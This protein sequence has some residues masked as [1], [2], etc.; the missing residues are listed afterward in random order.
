MRR[1]RP[2]GAR[3][4][5]IVLAAIG[6][7]LGLYLSA[8]GD[9]RIL[10]WYVAAASAAVLVMATLGLLED[11]WMAG[12]TAIVGIGGTALVIYWCIDVN[13]VLFRDALAPFAW[14]CLSVAVAVVALPVTALVERIRHGSAR[15]CRRSFAAT[16]LTLTFVFFAWAGADS[17]SLRLRLLLREDDFDAV[18]EQ[19][20]A[21]GQEGGFAGTSTPDFNSWMYPGPTLEPLSS[22]G[23]VSVLYGA[24]QLDPPSMRFCL[25]DSSTLCDREIVYAPEGEPGPTAWGSANVD[26]DAWHQHLHGDW[27]YTLPYCPRA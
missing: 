6:L 3:L 14:L 1:G 10:G 20:L 25:A 8:Y 17:G 16:F 11:R 24:V 21:A 12:T 4:V 2:G 27:Y 15:I 26:C 19:M 13:V 5:A 22:V 18:A 23:G 7:P 9:P